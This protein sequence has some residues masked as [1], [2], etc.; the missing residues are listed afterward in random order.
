MVSNNIHIYPSTF[1]N[2]SRI[3]RETK[4]LAEFGLFDK[5]FIAAMW[6]RGLKE[7]EDLDERRKV[8]R[9]RLKTAT[10]PNSNLGKIIKH[11]EW[12]FRIFF[13]F[14]NESITFINC[15]SLSTLPLGAILKMF[16][17]AKLIYDAHELE[18]E[19]MALYGIRKILSKILERI[20]IYYTDQVIVVSHSIA[21]WYQ[22][23]YYLNNIHVIRNFPYRLDGEGN[24]PNVLRIDLNIRD[25]EMI[26]IYQGVLSRGRG[27]EL[28]LNVF[29]ELDKK[30]HVVFMGYGILEDIVKEYA[31]NYSNIHFWPAVKPNEIIRYTMCADIGIC[32]I[33]NICLSYYYALPNKLFEYITSGL[34]VV[35]SDFPEM[36]KI[37]DDYKCG[38]KVLVDKKLLKALM[39]NISWKEIE[40]KKCNVLK[41]RPR[42]CWEKEAG[43][44]LHV[45]LG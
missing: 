3:L 7:Y 28:L 30:R 11:I 19:T 5:I 15:H 41:C 37:I 44:L 34:P 1:K 23:T 36:R 13:R 33:N 6:E 38:W 40:G 42:F 35:V 45:Y 20:F 24:F 25:D 22:N 18:T 4:S 43:K 8:W 9:V 10:L 26:F 32:L 27:I 29:S 16:V 31:N 17:K 2:E 21:K 39:E 14:K 12:S